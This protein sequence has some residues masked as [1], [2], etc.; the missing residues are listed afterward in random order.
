[1]IMLFRLIKRIFR[2]WAPDWYAKLSSLFVALMIINTIAVFEGYWWEETFQVVNAALLLAVAVDIIMPLRLRITKV[3][4]QAVLLLLSTITYIQFDKL[5]GKPESWNEWLDQ[6]WFY[7]KQLDP[8]I[9]FV[10]VLFIIYLLFS[11]WVTTRAR[12]IGFVTVNL[13]SLTIADS[14]TPIWLW[15]KVAWIVFLGLIWLVAAH[16]RRLERSHPRSWQELLEYPLQL[17]LPVAIVLALLMGV[18]VLMP[19]VSPILQDPYTIWKESK[20]ER[21]NVF[22]GDKG[23]NTP[24]QISTGDTSSGYGRDDTKLGGGFNYDYSPVMTVTTSQRA[25]WRGETKSFYSGKGW[26]NDNDERQQLIGAIARDMELPLLDH[27]RLAETLSVEQTIVMVRKDHY[28]VLFAASPISSVHWVG[29]S[30]SSIP[31]GLVWAANDHELSWSNWTMRDFPAAYSVRSDITVLDAEGLRKTKAERSS[32]TERYLQLPNELPQRVKQ[33]ALDITEGASNDYDRAKLL[34]TYLRDNYVYTNKPDM[35]KLGGS[36]KDFVDQF[37]FELKEGYCDY[38]S[39]AMAVMSRSLGLPARWVKGFAPGALPVSEYGPPGMSGGIPDEIDRNP[40][41]EGTYTVRNSDAHSWVEIYF[42]GY[43]WIPFEA[44]A[45][46]SF[47]YTLP[48]EAAPVMPDLTDIGDSPDTITAAQANNSL[49]KTGLWISA[50][51]LVALVAVWAVIRRKQF[52]Q[53]W[54][55]FR[56]RSFSSDERIVWETER[57]LR[58]CRRKGLERGEH[59]TLREALLR[60][61]DGGKPLQSDWREVL[62]GFERAKYSPVKSS[63]EDADRFVGKVKSIMQQL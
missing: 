45:G 37:L 30:E 58:K 42:D 57:L 25:Y 34:E 2:Y 19:T 23:L 60:W 48:A 61:S 8:Y 22:L 18:G 21:V 13:L 49:M 31:N 9:W 24:A 43:G 5:Y 52:V 12:M 33:L 50:S 29:K 63:N 41:G 11:K 3:I 46:F 6:L 28:P 10:C 54:R 51:L 1:M 44:T 32:Q 47:P 56:F 20:G 39:T 4:T 16:L 55:S 40:N 17:L 62:D 59:E 36:S 26:N 14:F 27:R 15:D 53:V 35:S 38:F 7:A